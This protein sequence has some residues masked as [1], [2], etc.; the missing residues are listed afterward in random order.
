V[1]INNPHRTELSGIPWLNQALD[2]FIGA[3]RA[4][5]HLEHNEDGTHGDV[6]ANSITTEENSIING[7]EVGTLPTADDSEATG[8]LLGTQ[9]KIVEAAEET[10]GAGSGTE[11]QFWDLTNGG[12]APAARL[13]WSTDRWIFFHGQGQTSAL[14][15]GTSSRRIDAMHVLDQTVITLLTSLGTNTLGATSATTLTTPALTM[16]GTQL[17]TGVINPA[18]LVA[19]TNNWNPTGLSTARLVIFGTDASRNI[20]GLV[21]QSAGRLVTLMNGG[22]FDAVL[23]ASDANSSAA[24]QFILP[25]LADVTMTP[26]SSVTLYYDGNQPLWRFWS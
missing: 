21:A 11:L 14:Q 24:N 3:L 26:G 5:G 8:I 18:T 15:F 25:G 6:T 12:T 23:K 22:A 13:V 10:P 16:S 7:A 1:I 9:W 17:T 19:N 2:K 20:T 4:W